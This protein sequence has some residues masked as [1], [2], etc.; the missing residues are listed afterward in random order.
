MQGSFLAVLLLCATDEGGKPPSPLN[1]PCHHSHHSPLPTAHMLS[2]RQDRSCYQGL[3]F[4]LSHFKEIP[5]PHQDTAY[6]TL[7]LPSHLPLGPALWGPAGPR[8]HQVGSSARDCLVGPQPSA[9]SF[10]HPRGVL[11]AYGAASKVH[12]CLTAYCTGAVAFAAGDNAGSSGTE[13]CIW[14]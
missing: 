6:F 2:S 11:A 9:M 13:Q 4:A 8:H 14:R 7:G 5:C 12:L 1:E 3:P 10:C